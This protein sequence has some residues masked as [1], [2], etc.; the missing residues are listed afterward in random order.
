MIKKNNSNP[1]LVTQV[2]VKKI[3]VYYSVFYTI[4]IKKM[5]LKKEKEKT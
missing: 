4:F 5:V 1:S 3:C 2:G